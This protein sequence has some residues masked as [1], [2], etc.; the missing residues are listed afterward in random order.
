MDA[1]EE[2]GEPV[3]CADPVTHK[4]R[5]LA[6]QCPTCILRPGNLMYLREG[7]LAELMRDAG[8]EGCQGMICHD[9][10]PGVAPQDYAPALCRGWYDRFGQRN[11]YVRVMSR[12]GGITEVPLPREELGT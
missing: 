9:T 11:N 10:L 7:R 1:D 4:A 6:E 8:R 3:S 5:L 2:Y 12:L